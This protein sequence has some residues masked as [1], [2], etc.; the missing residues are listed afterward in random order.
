MPPVRV[1]TRVADRNFHVFVN[2]GTGERRYFE[3][4][5]A[6]YSALAVA[7]AGAPARPGSVPAAF[8]RWG[9]SLGGVLTFN[10]TSGNPENNDMYLLD[11]VW[12]VKFQDTL[13]QSFVYRLLPSTYLVVTT[14]S[15]T[16]TPA[17]PGIT[18]TAG[19]ITI[20][21]PGDPGHP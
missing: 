2:P 13:G 21:G 7:G 17:A 18:I 12:H 1:I 8:S 5:N 15:I 14:P 20:V 19:V 4:N 10:T 3:I 9:Y 11:G 16:V 6:A